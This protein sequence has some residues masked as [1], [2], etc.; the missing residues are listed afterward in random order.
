MTKATIVNCH[1]AS[2]RRDVNDPDTLS[3][4][5]ATLKEGDTILIDTSRVYWSWNDKQY[6]KCSYGMNEDEGYILTSL[7]RYKGE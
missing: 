1:E 7:V 3:D 6:Y 2:I 4:T 5:I